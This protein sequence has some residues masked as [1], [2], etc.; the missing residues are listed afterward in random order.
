MKRPE[1][2]VII[3]IRNKCK[4]APIKTKTFIDFNVTNLV[5]NQLKLIF[6]KTLIL[7]KLLATGINWQILWFVQ[8]HLT[9]LKQLSNS[10]T[11]RHSSP[12]LSYQNWDSA[13]YYIQ[14]Q[15]H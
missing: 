1:D 10:W 6:L 5:D 12:R 11:K 13:M 3:P 7:W 4:I 2:E 15:I 9:A 14:I 8:R